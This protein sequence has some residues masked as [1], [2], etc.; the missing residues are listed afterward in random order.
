MSIQVA[1]MG[2]G[3]VAKQNYL[4]H[5]VAY[6]DIELSYYNRSR[7]KAEALAEQFGGRVASSVAELMSYAP[8]T[9]LVLTR[10][11][12]RFDAATALLPYKPRRLF[13]EKPLVAQRGQADVGEDD[14]LQGKQLLH[15]AH[16]IGTETAMVFNYRFFDQTQ[17]AAEII[18]AQDFG[19][20]RHFSG[21][22]HYACWSHCIDLVLHFMG[23]AHTVSALATQKAGPCMGADTV[24]DVT[25]SAHM[26]NDAT[27]TL[28]GTCG[29]DFKLPLY[30]LTFA[31][32][33]GR[34]HMRDLDGEM[35]VIDYRTGRHEVHA[36][37][38]DISRWDQYRASFGKAIDAYLDSVR[39]GVSPPVP[40][41]AGLR[42]LQFEAGIKRSIARAAPVVLE[43]A[44][45]LR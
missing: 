4:P 23:A 37:P 31:Y 36:L 8:D 41:M 38:W 27:G 7:D 16:R 30:E 33:H 39:L 13:F 11:T 12:D 6:E 2:T 42:E 14:F 17:R 1:I 45:P 43:E 29:I 5:I 19:S 26:D 34:I 10:E 18:A 15:R 40:G 44:F 25:V 24:R 22:V 32:E 9:V 21:L 35:E 28:I 3:N 20:P